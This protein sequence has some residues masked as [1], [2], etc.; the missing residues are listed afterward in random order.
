MW[1]VTGLS[2][3]FIWAVYKVAENLV[4]PIERAIAMLFVA[5]VTK[6]VVE[7]LFNLHRFIMSIRLRIDPFDHEAWSRGSDILYALA[8]ALVAAA[9]GALYFLWR[10]PHAP[11][12]LLLTFV[13]GV[14]FA[15]RAHRQQSQILPRM[16]ARS[17]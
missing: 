2:M 4:G 13:V 12:F 7:I 14:A 17:V 8:F 10:D 15:L 11:L 3:P 16:A 5:V 1:A 9:F 6:I